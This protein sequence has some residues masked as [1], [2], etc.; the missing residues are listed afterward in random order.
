MDSNI[1]P[2]AADFLY[3][4]TTDI[5]TSVGS[6]YINTSGYAQYGAMR[7]TTYAAIEGSGTVG[8]TTQPPAGTNPGYNLGFKDQIE[9]WTPSIAFGAPLDWQ[10]CLTL[11]SFT[12]GF[13]P[14][15]SSTSAS[16]RLGS[17]PAMNLSHAASGTQSTFICRTYT[18]ANG[19]SLSLF[20]G[21]GNSVLASGAGSY[22]LG[23]EIEVTI[24]PLTNP[25]AVF[26]S[27]SGYAYAVPEPG[28]LAAIGAGLLLLARRRRK[29]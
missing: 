5:P 9:F 24:R 25:N 4:N 3:D 15:A 26:S 22:Y 20:G 12:S 7:L 10:I 27:C 23:S 13:S 6:A 18:I 8:S 19:D 17:N 11:K 16:V 29:A 2:D 21:L 1:L 14:T 28:S